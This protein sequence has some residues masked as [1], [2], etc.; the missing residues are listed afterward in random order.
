MEAALPLK[1]RSIITLHGSTSQKTILNFPWISFRSTELPP[2]TA[3][4]DCWCGAWHCQFYFCALKW[5][6]RESPAIQAA[7]RG[8][9]PKWRLPD[10]S[11]SGTFW[12]RDYWIS[13]IIMGT[14]C[15]C[16][17]VS[18]FGRQYC[19]AVCQQ[20]RIKGRASRA[21]ARG[22]YLVGALKQLE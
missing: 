5:L 6:Q 2:N 15:P 21:A 20:G 18:P 12:T 19:D 9:P 17:P 13:G 1:R 3:R 11:E 4:N 22:F 14:F 8:N 16:L 10:G 7:T